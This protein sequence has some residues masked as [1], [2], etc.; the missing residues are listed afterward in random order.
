MIVWCVV[1]GAFIWKMREACNYRGSLLESNRL[2]F[3][4]QRI[5]MGFSPLASH[6]RTLGSPRR[7][8]WFLNLMSNCGGAGLWRL[9]YKLLGK[10][11]LK[12]SY[13]YLEHWLKWQPIVLHR[14]RWKLHINNNLRWIFGCCQWIECRLQCGRS[15]WSGC[16]G[17]RSEYFLFPS[18][19][20][21]MH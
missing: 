10:K 9:F 15:C 13:G 6:W 16:P 3:M 7:A 2:L 5:P 12:G 20:Y 4:F 14:C 19:S 18:V 11:G 8:V 21:H 17:N 1:L